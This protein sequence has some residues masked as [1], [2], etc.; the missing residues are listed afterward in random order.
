MNNNKHNLPRFLISRLLV[1]IAL[2]SLLSAGATANDISAQQ[3]IPQTAEVLTLRSG[4]SITLAIPANSRFL[5][6]QNIGIDSI[7]EWHDADG[8]VRAAAA[9]WRGREGRYVLDLNPASTGT[10]RL[11][12]PDNFAM[13]GK[14]ELSWFDEQSLSQHAV[15]ALMHWSQAANFHLEALNGDASRRDEAIASY[16]KSVR[17]IAS[18]EMS[19]LVGDLYYEIAQ[20]QRIAG[21]L[22]LAQASYVQAL[23]AYQVTD[24]AGGI[25]ATYNGLGRTAKSRGNLDESIRLYHRSL[26]ERQQLT[27]QGNPHNKLYQAITLNNI[28][29]VNLEQDRYDQAIKAFSE[30]LPVLAGVSGHSVDAVLGMSAAEIGERGDLSETVNT[31]NN[32]AVSFAAIGEVDRAA[33]IYERTMLL[34]TETNQVKRVAD[35]HFNIGRLLVDLGQLDASLR[36]LDSAAAIYADLQN[37]FWYGQTLEWI[38]NIYNAVG[39]HATA[40]EY[41]TRALALS[42]QNQ[43]QRANVLSR[44]G[45]VDYQQGALSSADYYFGQSYDSFASNGQP[46][47]AAVVSSEHALVE[48]AQGETASALRKQRQSIEVLE[49]LGQP[50]EVARARSRLGQ[51]LL[52]TGDLEAAERELNTALDGHRAVHD[53]LFELDTLVALSSARSG[54]AALDTIQ[55]AATLASSIRLN[56]RAPQL[57]TSFMASRRH[58]FGQYIDLLVAANR[59]D[60]AWAVSEHVR[61]RS[62]LDLINDDHAITSDSALGKRRDMMLEALANSQD[63]MQTQQLRRQLDLL[64]SRMRDG[65][66]LD[67][68]VEF[69]PV[70]KSLQAELAD[71]VLMISYFLGEQHSHLWLATIDSIQHHLLPA[72]SEITA[73][74]HALTDALRSHRQSPSRIDFMAAQLREQI[75][76]L[77]SSELTGRELVIVADGALQMVPF[78]LLPVA[79]NEL[80]MDRSTV[81]YSP[82]ARLFAMLDNNFTISPSSIA[83]LADP[84]A[85]SGN[86]LALTEQAGIGASNLFAQRALQQSAINVDRLPGARNEAMA[87]QQR[88]A[89]TSNLQPINRVSMVTGSEASRD[90]VRSGGLQGFGILHFATHGVID[91]DVPELSGLVI[92]GDPDSGEKMSYL[93]PHEIAD[94]QLDADLVVL[95]GCETG[96]GKS[97]AGEGLMSL[98]RPFFVAGARQ[99]ISSLWKVSD[100]ATAALMEHFYSHL[101]DDRQPAEQALKMA[102]EDMRA[103]PQWQHPYFWAGFVL[104]GGRAHQTPDPALQEQE[105]AATNS[106]ARQNMISAALMGTSIP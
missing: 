11:Y 85:D 91:A 89:A 9:T 57:Q 40:E 42:G 64:E 30:A 8:A 94:L 6:V 68:M 36:H 96:I 23:A 98:S 69:H 87:I 48:M 80:L 74:V 20:A 34:A 32:L 63:S 10:I 50:R 60:E 58:A 7:A 15:T 55:D 65:I 102:K 86:M 41:L 93:R 77:D 37:D 13:H 59:A 43:R 79:N 76:P 61:A 101:L 2:S 16:Q 82:S 46:G 97:L 1:L 33:A 105:V 70:A 45:Q 4:D 83:V 88:V 81:I 54:Q 5:L 53:Q 49:R 35:A 28:S 27:D 17:S 106:E 78:G 104:Q 19:D 44:L 66:T 72:G 56:T 95:S 12:N 92:S 52:E 84:L 67:E 71:D 47:S 100:Q 90:Y 25:A 14:V 73:N 75:L 103:D 3:T 24:D 39:E 38:A 22:E 62:L 99:V 51:L 29:I 21:D 18:S 31:M 26:L